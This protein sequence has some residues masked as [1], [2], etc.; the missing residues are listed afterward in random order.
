MRE[1]GK[2]RCIRYDESILVNELN[3][4]LDSANCKFWWICLRP[5]F[6]R[7]QFTDQK[8]RFPPTWPKKS[9]SSSTETWD[10][11]FF[12]NQI[13]GDFFQEPDSWWLVEVALGEHSSFD[14][15]W[16]NW[17]LSITV[18]KHY[19]GNWHR[20]V[21]FHRTVVLFTLWRNKSLRSIIS[22][23]LEGLRSQP[24]PGGVRQ[25]P[26]SHE[27]GRQPQPRLFQISKCALQP[28][29]QLQPSNHQAHPGNW[30]T[31]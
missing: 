21:I 1:Y 24:E 27:G 7:F 14:Q 23:S 22:E 3:L 15:L 19:F 9:W 16:E 26:G 8:N 29:K 17:E 30:H 28:Q 2:W 20:R 4:I 12:G 31:I 11:T 13:L 10:E 18:I 6:S 25:G 5:T